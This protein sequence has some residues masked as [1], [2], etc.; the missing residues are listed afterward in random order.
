MR[1]HKEIAEFLIEN[2]ARLDKGD[3]WGKTPLMAAVFYNHSEVVKLLI[4]KGADVC[5]S[6]NGGTGETIRSRCRG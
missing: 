6:S 1:G 4:E 5:I 2:G 3:S